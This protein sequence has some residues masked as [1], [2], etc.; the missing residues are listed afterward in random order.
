[1]SSSL[2]NRT[3]SI[4]YVHDDDAPALRFG[5]L[6]RGDVDDDEEEDDYHRNNSLFMYNSE[7]D[8]YRLNSKKKSRIST[9]SNLDRIVEDEKEE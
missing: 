8:I 5:S 3:Q 9:N 1:M 4:K 2:V 6:D 7:E